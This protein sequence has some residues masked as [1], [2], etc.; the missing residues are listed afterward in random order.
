M[1][2]LLCYE[3]IAGVERGDTAR[4]EHL[5]A[6]M[7]QRAFA[8]RSRSIGSGTCCEA[9]AWKQARAAVDFGTRDR[10]GAERLALR[11]TLAWRLAGDARCASRLEGGCESASSRSS[12]S[13]PALPDM[14]ALEHALRRLHAE[15]G[16]FVGPI[17]VAAGPR[18]TAPSS[19]RP[20]PASVPFARQWCPPSSTTFMTCPRAMPTSLS[21]RAG[22]GEFAFS[23]SWSV[24]LRGAGFHADSVA[25]GMDELRSVHSHEMAAR[26]TRT[27]RSRLADHGECQPAGL[28]KDI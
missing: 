13:A 3:A 6:G 16:E 5:F 1:K 12:T 17:G 7:S 18:R 15:N 27:G 25:P 21:A 11:R 2:T 28:A 19:P 4:A 20:I 8:P 22:T 26:R 14:K 24:L 23:G 9:T 10:P